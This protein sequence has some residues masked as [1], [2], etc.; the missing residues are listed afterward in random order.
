[1]TDNKLLDLFESLSGVEKREATKFLQSPFFNQR[2]DVYRL[3]ELLLSGKGRED[4]AMLYAIV[5]PGQGFEPSK[6]RHLQS[7]LVARIED[8]LTQRAWDK[9]PMLHEIELAPVLRQKG[10]HKPLEAVLRRAGKRLESLPRD[11]EYYYWQYRLEWEQY[12]AVESQARTRENNLAAVGLAFDTFLIA[13]KLRLACLTESHKAVYNTAYEP[14]LLPALLQYT[15]T[16]GLLQTPIVALY[17]HCYQAL[18]VGAEA[19]FRAFRRELEQQSAELP[20]DERRTLLLLALNY[21]I[22]RLNSGEAPYIREA[23]EL[24]RVGLD[25]GSLLESGHL[26]RFAFKNIVALGLRLEQ[27]GWVEHFIRESDMLLEAK[28]REANRNYN[29]ARL[30][31]TRKD[32]QKAMPLLALVDESDLLLNLDSRIML[33]KMYYETG[34]WDALDALISSFKIL[35]LRKKKVIGY[36]QTHYLNILRYIQKL[37]RLNFT[38]KK[39]VAMLREVIQNDTSVIEKEWLLGKLG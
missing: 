20:D 16:S 18:K 11:H 33:L 26:S 14:G 37:V 6:W 4:A 30:H 17:Y 8:F 27:F 13:G 3:W 25:T 12:A 5:C 7:F 29:L 28:Y 35:L 31:F 32:Y 22:R 15:E 24:Y 39:A 21:C 9:M 10:L 34:E 2:E 36:H 1:M 38:D 19:D 23:F